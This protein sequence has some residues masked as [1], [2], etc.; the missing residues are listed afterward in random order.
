MTIVWV[1][2]VAV[3]MVLVVGV[4]VVVYIGLVIGAITVD[5]ARGRRLRPLGPLTMDI[6]AERDVVFELLAQPYQGRTTRALQEK[7]T[8]LERGSDMVLAAHRTPVGAGLT[9]VTVETVRFAAPAR[10]DFRLVR[11]PVPH[12]VEQFTLTER[13]DGTRLE[14]CGELGTDGWAIGGWWGRVVGNKWQA[15]VAVTLA[16]VKTEAERRAARG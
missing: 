14:Y 8:V 3:V 10:I 16:S 12:V 2:I 15:A 11:G 5:I 7:V 9:A 6:A 13:P 4:A 1:I